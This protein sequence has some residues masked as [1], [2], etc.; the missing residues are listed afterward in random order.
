MQVLADGFAARMQ[1]AHHYLCQVVWIIVKVRPNGVGTTTELDF[2][3]HEIRWPPV[4][5]RHDST[6]FPKLC[7]RKGPVINESNVQTR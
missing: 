4:S 3:V 5:I 1:V 7:A 6:V 2:N